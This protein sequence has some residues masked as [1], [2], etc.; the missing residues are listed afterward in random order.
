MKTPFLNISVLFLLIIGLILISSFLD[1]TCSDNRDSHAGFGFL[2]LEQKSGSP[3]SLNSFAKEEIE[4]AYKLT[5]GWLD[6]Q[7]GIHFITFPIS[8]KELSDAD[9]EFG[10]YE[11]ELEEYVEAGVSKMREEML[12]H[13]KQFVTQLKAK[14]RY[15]QYILIEEVDSL[16][17]KL[18]LSVPPASYKEAKADFERIKASLASEQDSYF[19]KIEK[20]R[21]KNKRTFLEKRGLRIIGNEIGVNY[22]LCTQN[23]RPRVKQVFEEMLKTNE[24]LNLQQFLALIL[25]FIQEVMYGTPPMK[26]GDKLILGFF[27]PP[28]VLVEDFGDCD[29]KGV[30]FASLWI[31]FKNYPMILIKIPNHMF[32]GLAIPSFSQEGV[33]INGLRY[34]LCEVT[35]P[36]KI[37]P[38]MVT[39][40]SQ[41]YLQGGQYRYEMIR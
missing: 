34:T 32:V 24:N 11:P 41:L 27:T 1:G 18:K 29:S 17:F 14:S 19:K 38:G 3:K 12:I 37:P 7:G 4:G 36:D 20:E 13:L 35:G 30:T 6:Y 23:N 33:T 5:Y 10:Y 26:E 2:S 21:E 8:K 25:S 40:Y 9:D 31:N 28:K 15:S 16:N 39:S 22:Q